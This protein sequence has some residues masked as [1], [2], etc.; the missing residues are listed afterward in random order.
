[1]YYD[2]I[3]VFPG[4]GDGSFQAPILTLT[5][6]QSYGLAV[7]D[8]NGDGHPDLAIGNRDV[9]GVRIYLGNGD[10]KFTAHGQ[11]PTTSAIASLAAGHID[12]G[13]TIDLAAAV[14]D[15]TV[16]YWN[17]VGDGSFGPSTTLTLG[18][19][20]NAVLIADLN[21]DGSADLVVGV[22]FYVAVFYNN[23]DGTF[24]AALEYPLNFQ[25]NKIVSGDF[26]GDGRP[27][28]AVLN[29]T[30]YYQIGIVAV[31]LQ[32]PSGGLTDSSSY[33]AGFYTSDLATGDF[34]GDGTD[35]VAAANAGS[36][37][38]SVL[39]ADAAGGMRAI[40]VAPIPI[41][42]QDIA[43][44]DFSGSGHTEFAV[45]NGNNGP[46][47]TMLSLD[48]HG[49]LVTGPSTSLAPYSPQNIIAADLDSD[50]KLDLALGDYSAGVVVLFGNGDGTFGP[51][52]AYFVGFNATN[53]AA[54]DF[55]GDGRRDLAA[56]SSDGSFGTLNVL[57]N[58]GGGVFAQTASI[59]LTHPS[60]HM[61]S[62]DLNGDGAWDLVTVDGSSC[63]SQPYVAT[64]FLSN[65]DGTFLGGVDYA[66]GAGPVWVEAADFDEDGSQDLVTADAN[67]ANVSILK[68]DGSGGFGPPTL[69]AIG[70]STVDV[71]VGDFDG[72]GHQ[73]ILGVSS[74]TNRA[75]L[76]RGLGNGAFQLPETYVVGAGPYR[77]F[78]GHFLGSAPGAAILNSDG[79]FSFLV[80][81]KLSAQVADQS[82]IVG[83][84]A[85]LTV[86][87]FGVGPITY[88]WRK[89][90]IPLSD[91]GTISGA[92]TATLTID[93]VAFTDA[94]SYDVVV[95]DSCT[96]AT[97][98]A[99]A[100]SV[101][102]DDVPLSN[103]FH[104]DIITIA[105]AGITSGC[106][107][108][109]YCPSHDV[110]RA[111]M[112]VLLL[113]SKYGSGHV[114]PPPPVDPI[115]AD[116]PAD[117]FA[118]A[119]IDELAILGVTAGCGNGNYCPDD[120]VTRGQMAVFL[121]K[122]LLGSGYVPPP[123]VGLFA[124]VPAGYFAIDWIEDLYNRGI[125]AGCGTNPPRYCPDADVPREQMATFL[126]RT[127][128]TP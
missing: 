120:P 32:D 117:A 49:R 36:G 8:F 79:T 112:A 66:T 61:I 19:T 93:P 75:A 106:T 81:A 46:Q 96:N 12:A 102:F 5:G 13:G 86:S 116:V 77:A 2:A 41:S 29:S 15:G 110:S 128:L 103:P 42:W 99:A 94:G 22:D 74:Q 91:G 67:A 109:S 89:N 88:Q 3:R 37:T 105:T 101:E 51:P 30:N 73:D 123:A 54:G 111:E 58:M 63:C 56:I 59:P 23:G 39:L 64:V 98:N 72:D 21:G 1:M 125:T 33:S 114:P 107:T 95:T 17:G 52:N 65:G 11:L 118:A 20:V 85:V 35:D 76:L 113:K 14:G 53:V 26:N 28:I 10:G 62:A 126:V 25:V 24:Q 60:V 68:G 84:P 78:A 45:L 83:S 119:W 40:R 27:D 31:F 7:A 122:T 4:N 44:G 57:L 90:G 38:A 70:A 87:A 97:S 48:A 92:H 124:D 69:V 82:V 127:F 9:P 115:F 6:F 55:N 100:L 50:G 43:S 71:L 16:V 18:G 104:D 121:L 108:T 34:D 80:N 47:V